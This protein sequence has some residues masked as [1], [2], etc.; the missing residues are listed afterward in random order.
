M[1]REREKRERR[2]W[3]WERSSGCFVLRH[4]LSAALRGVRSDLRVSDSQGAGGLGR[5]GLE[6][7]G[8]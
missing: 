3:K 2:E 7:R 1:D 6:E 4:F 5:A 8:Q